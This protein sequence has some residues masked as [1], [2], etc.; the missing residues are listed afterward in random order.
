MSRELD[1]GVDR[2]VVPHHSADEPDD[3]RLRGE[4]YRDPL[5]HGGMVR[6]KASK[7]KS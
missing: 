6:K 5:T 1:L 7:N 2:V 3:Y 4:L